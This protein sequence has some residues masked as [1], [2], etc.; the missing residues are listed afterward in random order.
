MWL[1]RLLGEATPAGR[2]SAECSFVPDRV[3]DRDLARMV[4][5]ARPAGE[6]HLR[7]P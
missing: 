3:E 5:G 4:C 2:G 6:A 1:L 7:T